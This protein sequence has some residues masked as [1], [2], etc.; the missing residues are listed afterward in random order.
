LFFCFLPWPRWPAATNGFTKPKRR[1]TGRLGDKKRASP[2]R[3][4]TEGSANSFCHDRRL[5]IHRLPRISIFLPRRTTTRKSGHP[6]PAIAGAIE[7][8]SVATAHSRAAKSSP[9]AESSEVTRIGPEP[10]FALHAAAANA[11]AALAIEAIKPL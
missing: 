10:L 5:G 8:S 6:I 7:P 1:S 2:Q 4:G 11:R 3:G 9:L